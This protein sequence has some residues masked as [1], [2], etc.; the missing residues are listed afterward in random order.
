[1]DL[2]RFI[3]VSCLLA[4]QAGHLALDMRREGRLDPQPK[5]DRSMVTAA[6][7][8]ADQIIRGGLG[9]IFPNIPLIS[10]EGPQDIE[11]STDQPYVLIDPLD[12][13]H[14]FITGSD[15]FTVNIGLIFQTVPVAGIVYA[16]ALERLF[17]TDANGEAWEERSGGIA[18][19]LL[20]RS[21]SRPLRIAISRNRRDLAT[22]SYLKRYPES[23]AMRLTGSIKL[24]LLAAG[25]A[26]LYPRLRPIMEW[27][28][29]AG[30]AIL[31]AAGGMCFSF[32]D[33][34]ALA[35]G[36]PGWRSVPFVATAPLAPIVWL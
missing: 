32:D 12:G 7:I 28:T 34:S 23:V 27:D 5:L 21:A 8:A 17:Y 30:D 4:K 13:T 10:E 3:Q 20:L 22:E 6:D 29:A 36:R 35:Y 31:R 9:H 18:Q 33:R 16:P 1:M 15:H 11:V 25:E 26:D 14:D 24:C 2:A 19:R